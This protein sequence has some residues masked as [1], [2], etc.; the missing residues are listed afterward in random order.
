MCL[1]PIFERTITFSFNCCVFGC[2]LPIRQDL[3][4][5]DPSDNRRLT[6]VI[7]DDFDVSDFGQ[8]FVIMLVQ[9]YEACSSTLLTA[10]NEGQELFG[11]GIGITVPINAHFSVRQVDPELAELQENII[12]SWHSATKAVDL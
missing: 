2:Y 1:A 8:R 10:S 11:E 5:D 4:A 3:D 12:D 9:P 7:D 6:Q